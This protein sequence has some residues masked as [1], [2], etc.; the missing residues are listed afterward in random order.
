MAIHELFLRAQ[1]K[2]FVD[3]ESKCADLEKDLLEP[4]DV[5]AID[6]WKKR[7]DEFLSEVDSLIK[8][9]LIVKEDKGS[10]KEEPAAPVAVKIDQ[11]FDAMIAELSHSYRESCLAKIEDLEECTKSIFQKPTKENIGSL[12]KFLKNFSSSAAS[13][14]YPKLGRF[15][16]DFEYLLE[17]KETGMI[18]IGIAQEIK[19]KVEELPQTIREF[20]NE[21][22]SFTFEEEKKEKAPSSEIDLYLV[23]DNPEILSSI[24]KEGRTRGINVVVES[25]PSSAASNLSQG[26]FRAKFIVINARFLDNYNWI[27]D[28][29]K[30]KGTKAHFGL[31]YD[32][33]SLE[34]RLA[35]MEKNIEHLFEMP[36]SIEQ[37]LQATRSIAD[38]EFER[39]F[40]ILV[41]DDDLDICRL[42]KVH[43]EEIHFKVKTI[44]DPRAFFTTLG[45]FSPDLLLLDLNLPGYDGMDLL[46]SIR[47]DAKY[48]QLPVMVITASNDDE[49]IAKAFSMKVEDFIVK[50]IKKSLLQARVSSF[51]RIQNK[52]MLSQDHDLLTGL[53]SRR[54][55]YYLLQGFLERITERGVRHTL[56]LIGIDQYEEVFKAQSPHFAEQ[57]QLIVAN[58]LR[59]TFW[60]HNILG[61]AQESVFSLLLEGVDVAHAREQMESFIE[62]TLHDPFFVRN[63]HLQVAFS[64]GISTYPFDGV[65]ANTLFLAAQK[66]QHEAQIF[67]GIKILSYSGEK[68]VIKE[69]KEICSIDDD[70]DIHN[71][72]RFSFEKRGYAFTALENCEKAREYFHKRKGNMPSVVVI[73]RILTDGDGIDL[74]RELKA[75]YLNFPPTIFLTT[76]SSEEDVLLGLKEGAV[77]YIVKPFIMSIL[78]QKISK[79]IEKQ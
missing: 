54:S 77:D 27:D 37:I 2:H 1:Q 69:R 52:L 71:I 24:E 50:P 40:R 33:L 12:K 14:G 53:H 8:K 39:P 74:Y 70:P 26:A 21:E 10:F 63:K 66:A 62:T 5:Q 6:S 72:L 36:L 16:K 60:S 42:V 11:S 51:A 45:Q 58:S 31:I 65:D 13:Y 64:V 18:D 55:F 47:A 75:D 79:I 9:D 4:I 68:S 44:Q 30:N 22:P 67:D 57:L 61:K 28:Y 32:S 20:L 48:N 43:L 17:L 35:A 56:C 41:L 76:L 78:V 15:C 38:V 19:E 25:D 7:I 23:H 59:K 49:T 34:S 46:K 29:R 73:D 3:L